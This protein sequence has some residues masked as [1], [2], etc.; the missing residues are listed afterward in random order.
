[1]KKPI[2]IISVLT[3]TCGLALGADAKD[4]DK[5]E[6]KHV[7][8]ISAQGNA[9][10][11][12]EISREAVRECIVAL[13]TADAIEPEVVSDSRFL[14]EING[15]PNKNEWTKVFTAKLTINYQVYKKDLLIVTTKSVEGRDPTMKE[16]E[17]RLPH[18]KEFVSNPADG[19]TYAGRSN[20]QYYFTKVEDATGDVKSRAKVWLKQ[21]APLL[22]GDNK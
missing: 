7:T 4:K 5:W 2:A 21:Q 10:G 22:C 15:Q 6:K 9:D 16:V 18:S 3:L 20:R 12:S 19:D 14:K 11:S 17:K 13:P 1:M 8:V